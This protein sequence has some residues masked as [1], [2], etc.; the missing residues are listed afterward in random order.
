MSDAREVICANEPLWLTSWFSTDPDHA[1]GL[2]FFHSPDR[3]KLLSGYGSSTR[4]S[5][6]RFQTGHVRFVGPLTL[7][8]GQ[9]TGSKLYITPRLYMS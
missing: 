7:Y 3:W 5:P 8:N 1:L 6:A 4:G 2:I 9:T